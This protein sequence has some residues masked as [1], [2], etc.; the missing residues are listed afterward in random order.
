MRVHSLLE[1][2]DNNVAE[3]NFMDQVTHVQ[4]LTVVSSHGRQILNCHGF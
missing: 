2:S 1:L 3:L 4:Y